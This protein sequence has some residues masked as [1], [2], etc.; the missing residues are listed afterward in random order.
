MSA[1]R[2]NSGTV[3][4]TQRLRL[5]GRFPRTRQRAALLS[6]RRG[7]HGRDRSVRR[8][9]ARQL[10]LLSQALRRRLAEAGGTSQTY[11][12]RWPQTCKYL[13]GI[14]SKLNKSL[15]AGC[16]AWPNRGNSPKPPREYGNPSISTRRVSAW[17]GDD[18]AGKFNRGWTSGALGEI[19]TIL[20]TY[21]RIDSFC[22]N[23]VRGT[24]RGAGR[25]DPL[26]FARCVASGSEGNRACSSSNPVP[27]TKSVET[28]AIL[29]DC[30]GLL[31]GGS[32]PQY[33]QWPGSQVQAARHR[34]V[35]TS[36][37]WVDEIFFWHFFLFA[38]FVSQSP[39]QKRASFPL[40]ADSLFA[41]FSKL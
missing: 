5:R 34:A 17:R 1:L 32:R 15:I 18:H 19:R 23:L 9:G 8:E 37:D 13:T 10:R 33:H 6:E 11:R 35:E 25:K 28:P 29:I 12:G 14:G 31:L 39:R 4:R 26:G 40:L 30:W 21:L 3:P 20:L 38:M 24:G 2:V 16:Y 36:W 27:A 7:D 22:C 41:M